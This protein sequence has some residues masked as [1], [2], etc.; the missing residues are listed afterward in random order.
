MLLCVSSDRVLRW[1]SIIH[2]LRNQSA[3]SGTAAHTLSTIA[4]DD[5]VPVASTVAESV[6]RRS[7]TAQK[8]SKSS[9]RHGNS[10]SRC[11]TAMEM[12]GQ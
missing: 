10:V 1:H 3:L 12:C 9:D 4:A 6:I 2:W 8:S 5:D 7:F 11:D